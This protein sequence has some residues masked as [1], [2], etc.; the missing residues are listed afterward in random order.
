MCMLSCFSHVQ[1]FV[2]PG[3]VARQAPLSVGFSRQE[4]WSGL[5]CPPPR[6]LPDPGI[7]LKSLKSPVVAGDFSTIS[8]KPKYA[9][10]LLQISSLITLLIIL[11]ATSAITELTERKKKCLHY[12]RLLEFHESF[13]SCH[14]DII[15]KY[16][17]IL[18]GVMW[19]QHLL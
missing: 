5:R 16:F 12:E 10:T 17:Q 1:L 8:A 4:Y 6:D 18:I 2:T 15:S 3:T 13:E 11:V 14:G 9:G 7:E 19:E